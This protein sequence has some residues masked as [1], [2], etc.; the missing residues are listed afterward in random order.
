MRIVNKYGRS[1]LL[2][3]MAFG[4]GASA[5]ADSPTSQAT[6]ETFSS[7][8]DDIQSVTDFSG[9]EFDKW[10]AGSNFYND[11]LDLGF[12]LKLGNIVL[13]PWY[14]GY[15]VD[16]DA[17]N[18]ETKTVSVL[19]NTDNGSTY[20]TGE[21]ITLTPYSTS[22]ENLNS[23]FAIL[24]GLPLSDTFAFGAKLGYSNEGTVT[25]KGTYWNQSS[26]SGDTS[27]STETTI[28]TDG[29]VVS[30]S[31]TYYDDGGEA[32]TRVH[33]PY[34]EL[35]ATIGLG[36]MTLKPE[37]DFAYKMS[38]NYSSTKRTVYT[39]TDDGA[40]YPKTNEYDY[41]N[42]ENHLLP[43]LNVA[44]EMGDAAESFLHTFSLG[45][46]GDFGMFDDDG[47]TY[48]NSFSYANESNGY[49]YSV[50]SKSYKDYDEHS[51]SS[52][53]FNLGY[54]LEKEMEEGFTLKGGVGLAYTMSNSKYSYQTV[55]NNTT[56]YSYGDGT[57][58]VIY[59][60]TKNGSYEYEKTSNTFTPSLSGGVQYMITEKLRFNG[61]VGV[62]LPELTMT[63]TS[64]KT[65]ADGSTYTKTVAA[66]GT[67]T[68]TTTANGTSSSG[69][70]TKT[71][72]WS[73]ASSEAA[74]G[75]T[76]FLND[77]FSI[78]AAMSYSLGGSLA[79]SSNL[80]LGALLKY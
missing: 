48:K 65:S 74:I 9:V 16:A 62:A 42:K 55:T 76:F 33:M 70:D 68:E 77:N 44:L 53:T 12:G 39:T 80:S 38:E 19:K 4:L 17:T 61:G 71:A 52:H 6:K 73:S 26:M 7:E 20:K 23:D 34:L 27:G 47:D 1:L 79:T 14:K 45:W 28:G 32:G 8:T 69:T 46:E 58:R 49:T 10:L 51:A 63:E 31:G 37:L 72:T 36:S 60:T 13:A 22:E 57:E 56:R 78:D 54:M 50:S 29:T 43:A 75:F 5:F 21:T 2:A 11:K 64:T 15:I 40:W 66:N 67:I 25:Y 59:T 41:T 30:K 3:A 35:G 24:V 18:T